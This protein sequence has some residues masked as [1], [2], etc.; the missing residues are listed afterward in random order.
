MRRSFALISLEC[1]SVIMTLANGTPAFYVRQAE[2]TV[3]GQMYYDLG[4]SDWVFEIDQT[5]GQQIAD[6][7]MQIYSNPE[8]A[9]QLIE[10]NI[11]HATELVDAGAQDIKKL[12]NW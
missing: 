3:K 2:D 10:K 4:F 11:S 7:L 1:H 5:N 8:G 6:K 12:M 9:Q